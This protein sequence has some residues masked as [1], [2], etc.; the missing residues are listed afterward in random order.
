MRRR[1][2]K[3]HISLSKAPTLRAVRTEYSVRYHVFVNNK[4]NEQLFSF[5]RHPDFNLVMIKY[6]RLKHWLR[7]GLSFHHPTNLTSIE[8]IFW[9]S[10]TSPITKNLTTSIFNTTQPLQCFK[11]Y[12]LPSPKN[13]EKT[14]FKPKTTSPVRSQNK[15]DNKI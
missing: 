11:N 10:S 2:H 6:G 14:S 9:P 15:D 12:K 3:R 4:I 5:S 1:N 13:T 8:Q 7:K